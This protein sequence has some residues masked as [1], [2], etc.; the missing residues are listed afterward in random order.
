MLLKNIK[1]VVFDWDGT[2]M[3]STNRI[4]SSMQGAAK[5]THLPIPSSVSV[6]QLIGLN[7][8]VAFKTLFPF[9]S[10]QQS[11]QLFKHYRELYVSVDETPSPLYDGAENCLQRLKDNHIKL[12]I[13]TGKARFGF[14]RVL[15][16][17]PH[18]KPYLDDSICDDESESKP[19]P[20]M[21]IQLA[22]RQAMAFEQMLMVG[23]TEFDLMMA[24]NA[25][26]K[27]VG[28]SHGAHPVEQLLKCHPSKIIDHLDELK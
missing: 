24:L 19:K 3:D 10:K 11:E 9:A 28:V 25:G 15:N 27:C 22:N 17:V 23:D 1:L 21:L 18:I 2:L 12:A 20:D 13:A 6:K 5:I 14:E 7:L 4:V 16:E 26:V 8:Q